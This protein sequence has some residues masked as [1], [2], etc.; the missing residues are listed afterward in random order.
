MAIW[1]GIKGGGGGVVQPSLPPD[2]HQNCR[3][4]ALQSLMTPGPWPSVLANG[5]HTRAETALLACSA[6]Y[7]WVSLTFPWISSSG[8]D[9]RERWK[10]CGFILGG[11][12]PQCLSAGRIQEAFHVR[13]P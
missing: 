4:T 6:V 2:L 5:T 8:C 13:P 11:W 3:N 9:P 10:V 7:F 1:R 12:V